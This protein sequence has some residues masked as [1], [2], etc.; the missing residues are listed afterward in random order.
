MYEFHYEYMLP[1][2]GAERI[3]VLMTDTDSFIY[4]VETE[5]HYKDMGEDA[6]RFDFSNYPKDHA[7]Y[8][9]KNKKVLGKMKDETAGIPIKE[10]VG[11]RSMYSLLTSH[12]KEMKRAKGVKKST[13]KNDIIHRD[14]VHTL[15]SGETMRHLM[16]S[17]RSENHQIYS[18]EQNKISLSAFDDKRYLLQDGIT[19]YAYGHYRI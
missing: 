5:D 13:L 8:S 4:E 3:K 14:Y 12:G 7:L 16:R 1:K 9:E 18:L 19:S 15:F 2:Y 11:L 10:F 17:F 6:D